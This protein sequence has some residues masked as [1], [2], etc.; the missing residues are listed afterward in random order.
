[1]ETKRLSEESTTAIEGLLLEEKKAEYFY[2]H[3]MS[4][5]NELGLTNTA[6]YFQDE[7]KQEL[8][9]HTKLLRF[10]SDWNVCPTL[11]K[12]PPAYEEEGEEEDE[13]KSIEFQEL[14]EDAYKMEYALLEKYQK[15]AVAAFNR[16]E[17][18]VYQKFMEFVEIQQESV[19]EYNNL[20]NQ[21][22]MINNL[23]L[24]DTQ[25]MKK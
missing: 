14:F 25:I 7:A 4:L 19:V 13:A 12:I 22:A 15:E 18:Y 20:I 10:A 16:G 1:M 8:K 23:V 9:H 24:F 6:L 21:L 11:G 5:S 17:L 3:A 2:S